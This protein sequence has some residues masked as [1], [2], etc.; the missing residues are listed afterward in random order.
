MTIKIAPAS[1]FLVFYR[2]RIRPEYCGYVGRNT[3][4]NGLVVPFD[5]LSAAR[6]EC[7]RL[8][9]RQECEI[10]EYWRIW[11]EDELTAGEGSE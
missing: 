4:P 5:S 10:V 11:P 7:R 8:E 2:D 6:E 9:F 1:F 3:D